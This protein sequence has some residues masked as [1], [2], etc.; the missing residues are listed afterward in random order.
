MNDSTTV[1]DMAFGNI[2][3][4]QLSVKADTRNPC[5]DLRFGSMSFSPVSC[6]NEKRSAVSVCQPNL[7]NKE[8]PSK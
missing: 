8:N 7:I 6:N 5:H 2:S 4:F 3:P 1:K